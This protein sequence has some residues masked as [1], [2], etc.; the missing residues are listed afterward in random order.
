MAIVAVG[1][2]ATYYILKV[3]RAVASASANAGPESAQQYVAELYQE[4]YKVVRARVRSEGILDECNVRTDEFVELLDVGS[5]DQR[6]MA[7]FVLGVLLEEGHTPSA[8]LDRAARQADVHVSIATQSVL[9]LIRREAG[10]VA[11]PVSR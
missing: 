3:Y 5:T 2:S 6:L 8:H 1:S 11:Y 10:Q 4:Q 7:V 9:D